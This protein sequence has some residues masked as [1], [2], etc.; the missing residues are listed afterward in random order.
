[1]IMKQITVAAAVILNAKNQLLVVRKRHTQMFMQ[2]GGKLE[3]NETP[4]QTMLREITEEIAC[5]A[6][7]QQFIGRFETATANE[8]DHLLVSY[9][10]VVQLKQNPQIA[11]EIVEMKWVDLTDTDTPLAPLTRE[12]VM[13]WC[14]RQ[15]Q[16]I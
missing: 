1:M 8:P 12:I 13:P 10:Y 6:E 9:V 14:Q 5:E 2:V 4:E 11:A 3:M 7:I 15:L 16:P